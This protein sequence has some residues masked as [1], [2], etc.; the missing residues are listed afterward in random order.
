MKK[1][2]AFLCSIALILPMLASCSLEKDGGQAFYSFKDSLGSTVCLKERP[3]KV[4][5]LFSSYAEIWQIAGGR[6]D[7]TVKDAID[8]GYATDE[9][10][11]VHSGSGHSGINRE[12]LVAAS[13][14]LVIGT[15]DYPDQVDVCSFTASLGIPSALFRVESF[16]DYLN[17]LKIF[18]DILGTPERYEAYGTEVAAE[19]RMLKD[20]F[21]LKNERNLLFLRATKSTLKPMRSDGHFAA[22]MLTELGLENIADGAGDII[23]GNLLE[24]A[25]RCDPCYVFVTLMGDEEEAISYAEAELLKPGWSNLSAV[26]GSRVIYLPKALFQYKPNSRWAE[27]YRY[28]I[29]E[30]NERENF[31]D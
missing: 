6:V 31:H 27:A 7:I 18:T 12:L 3:K 11:I 4:A 1:A 24:Y 10:V 15:A 16:A 29:N 13:P 30:I 21:S 5:I 20:S 26:R 22:G 19:I 25:V 28:L 2:L 17:V 9:A 14:D 8:A 23:G